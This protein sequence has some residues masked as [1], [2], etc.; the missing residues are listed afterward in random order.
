M[1]EQK[2]KKESLFKVVGTLIRKFR[3]LKGLSQKELSKRTVNKIKPSYIGRIERGQ[4]N[5]SIETI[6]QIFVALDIDLANF[7]KCVFFAEKKEECHLILEKKSQI[8]KNIKS[9]GDYKMN[10]FFGFYNFF[11]VFF[12]GIEEKM[13]QNMGFAKV[14]SG[15]A[16]LKKDKE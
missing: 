9:F 16:K 2:K 12:K 13:E 14:A 11:S 10:F 15:V 5:P 1:F 6:D 7:L 3:K 4:Q 8:I